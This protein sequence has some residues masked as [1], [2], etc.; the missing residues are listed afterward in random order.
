[1]MRF[2]GMAG[3]QSPGMMM[4]VW[5]CDLEYCMLPNLAA[6]YCDRVAVSVLSSQIILLL[7]YCKDNNKNFVLI[8]LL[9]VLLFSIGNKRIITQFPFLSVSFLISYFKNISSQSLIHRLLI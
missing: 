8:I 6:G 2:H 7:E 4:F 3:K 9:I 5:M 1:M